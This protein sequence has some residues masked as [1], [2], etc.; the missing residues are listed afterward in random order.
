MKTIEKY[1]YPTEVTE[2]SFPQLVKRAKE[3]KSKS[4]VTFGIAIFVSIGLFIGAIILFILSYMPYLKTIQNPSILIEIYF[5]IAVG[6]SIF[7]SVFLIEWVNIGLRRICNNFISF[8][9]SPDEFIFAQFILTANLYSKKTALA[10]RVKFQTMNLCEEL[11]RYLILDPL[12]FKRKL[13]AK[14]FKLLASGQTQIGRMLVFSGSKTKELFANFAVSLVNNDDEIAYLYL[15]HI[16]EEVEKYGR[17]EA[18]AKRIENQ[19]KSWKGVVTIV[20]ALVAIIGTIVGLI[21][22]G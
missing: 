20:G 5:V 1:E 12:N 19:I 6:A 10:G 22:R 2:E 3:I 4:S 16:I 7:L 21:L 8:Y 14:E 17:L 15:T 9:P 18:I 13:Y 11:A